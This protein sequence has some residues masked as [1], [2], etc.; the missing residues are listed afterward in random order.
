MDTNHQH[1]CGVSDNS[2]D[3]RQ[4][5]SRAVCVNYMPNTTQT[6]L[7]I[8]ERPHATNCYVSICVNILLDTMIQLQPTKGTRHI[9]LEVNSPEFLWK[10]NCACI[11]QV[12]GLVT[13]LSMSFIGSYGR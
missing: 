1:C 8:N 12:V 11:T 6:Q 9:S 10:K 5:L 3:T 2:K 7:H 4:Q 13:S